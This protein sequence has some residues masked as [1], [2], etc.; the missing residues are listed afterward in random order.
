MTKWDEE[1]LILYFHTYMRGFYCVFYTYLSYKK[2]LELFSIRWQLF[3][4][5]N[6]I[7][8]SQMD[9]IP[10]TNSTIRSQLFE[11]RI[12]RIIR[13]NSVLDVYWCHLTLLLQTFW[14]IN[15][16]RGEVLITSPYKNLFRDL[17]DPIFLHKKS[18]GD[19]IPKEIF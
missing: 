6:I 19:K 14:A 13:C 9:R 1:N 16:C 3:G 17:F 10:N 18:W 7:R 12:I 5:S 4:Y 8:K 15:Y 2:I 11:Y